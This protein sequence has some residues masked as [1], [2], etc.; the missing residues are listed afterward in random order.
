MKEKKTKKITSIMVSTVVVLLLGGIWIDSYYSKIER[1][2]YKI[3]RTNSLVAGKLNNDSGDLYVAA[4]KVLE[5]GF[6]SEEKLEY[7]IAQSK[8]V[9]EKLFF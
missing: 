2:N 5:D 4:K 1:K 6:L 9:N 8:L 3:E 7:M